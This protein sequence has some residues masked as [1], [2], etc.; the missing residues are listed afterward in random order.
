MF[1]SKIWTQVAGQQGVYEKMI[2]ERRE[3]SIFAERKQACALFANKHYNLYFN[4]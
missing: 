2:C 4:L 3:N 1:Q